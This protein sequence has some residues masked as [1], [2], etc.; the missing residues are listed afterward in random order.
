MKV[1]SQVMLS[2]LDHKY[3]HVRMVAVWW[4]QEWKNLCRE[5]W[6]TQWQLAKHTMLLSELK[7]A[8]IASL[9]N[10]ATVT[11]SHSKVSCCSSKTFNIDSFYLCSRSFS[12]CVL[13]Q[14]HYLWN[15]LCNIVTFTCKIR[16]IL[17]SSTSVLFLLVVVGRNCDS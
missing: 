6:H 1:S 5:S 4:L 15:P 11:S 13:W 3:C 2:L 7:T 9:E 14:Q 17:W 8:T 12:K 10:L 16:Y